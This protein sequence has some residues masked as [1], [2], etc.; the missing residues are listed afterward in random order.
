MEDEVNQ[1]LLDHFRQITEEEKE[2]LA[3]RDTIHKEIYTSAKD[4]T[5]DSKKMLAKG[6]LIDIRTHTRFIHFP[7]HRHNYIE[8]IYMCSGSTT[9]IINGKTKIKL[10]AG[11][12]LFLNQFAYHEIEKAGEEDIAVNFL[13]LPE[14]FDQAF[15]MVGKDN[16]LSSFLLSSLQREAG[17]ISYLYFKVADFLPVQNLAENLVWSIANRQSN[18]RK[19]NQ[20][21]MGL[22]FLQLLNATDKIE[23][24]T[25]TQFENT[26]V[27][28]VIRQIEENYKNIQL[29]DLASEMKQSVTGLSKL[30]KKQT[31]QTFKELLQQKRFS[32]AIQ[33]LTN[34]GLSIS[35]IILAVGYE[36]TSYFYRVF[37]KIYGMSPH[38]YREM[39]H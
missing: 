33:L 8:I 4:F 23:R 22:L 37:K 1:E 21:T 17:E 32:K 24:D 15:D 26:L 18:N 9:H 7:K 6:K 34:T 39:N 16:L 10:N 28:E 12:F 36:N 31:S 25:P 29:T 20:M 13:V 19:L 27:I 11:E 35:E 5:I 38:D 30:I 3:G 2:I 14:F